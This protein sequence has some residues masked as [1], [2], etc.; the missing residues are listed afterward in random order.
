MGKVQITTKGI[1]KFLKSY[2]EEKS[3]SEYIWNGFDADA[4]TVDVITTSNDIG[5]IEKVEIVD[6]GTGID[7][8]KLS[9]KFVPFY[10]SEKSNNSNIKISKVHGKNGLGRLTFFCFASNAKWE[11]VYSNG[12]ENKKYIIEINSNELESYSTQSEEKTDENIGTKVV[13][14]NI[15]K[16]IDIEV[17]KKYLVLEFGWYL[18]LYDNK[19]LKLNGKI[20]DY[21]DNVVDQDCFELEDKENCQKF[22]IEYIQW[23]EKINEEYSRYYFINSNILSKSFSESYGISIFLVFIFTF[24]PTFSRIIFS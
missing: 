20:I 11:T 6:N 5:K 3:I 7:F 19:V 4:T 8:E 21:K 1:S 13:L 10:Q 2:T 23:N 9:S 18:K 17:L 12:K 15:N 24:V 22:N 16:M 14:Y